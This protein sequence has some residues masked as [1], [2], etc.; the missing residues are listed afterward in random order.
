MDGDKKVWILLAKWS[1]ILVNLHKS[2]EQWLIALT[3]RRTALT[4]GRG[5]L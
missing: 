5:C 1:P 4:P 2:S 3:T